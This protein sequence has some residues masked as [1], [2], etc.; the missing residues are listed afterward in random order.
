VQLLFEMNHLGPNPDT[1]ENNLSCSIRDTAAQLHGLAK[2]KFGKEV[3]LQLEIVIV[4]IS[5]A[6]IGIDEH[7][8]PPRD[9]FSAFL[10]MSAGMAALL[11]VPAW[12][13]SVTIHWVVSKHL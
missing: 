7:N 8:L 3:L 12:L 1:I 13:D 11:Q 6:L 10:V 9:A 4:F 5:G 2:F